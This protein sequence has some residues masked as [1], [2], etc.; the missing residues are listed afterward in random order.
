MFAIDLGKAGSTPKMKQENIKFNVQL[1]KVSHCTCNQKEA[2][3]IGGGGRG[4][5]VY[6]E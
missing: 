1:V 6:R 5:S 4:G 2:Q 3:S